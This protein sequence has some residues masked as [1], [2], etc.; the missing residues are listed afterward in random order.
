MEGTI[1]LL[2]G[3]EWD[4]AELVEKMYDDTFYY[5]YLGKAALSSSSM[6]KLTLS[7]EDYQDSLVRKFDS[8]A[9]IIGRLVHVA[10]LQPELIESMYQFIDCK[11][12]GSRL[13]KDALALSKEQEEHY[14]VVLEKD[15]IW[16]NEIRDAVL[17]HKTAAKLLSNGK[18]EIP[19]IDNIMGVP[20]RAKADWLRDD[21]IVD[22]KTTSNIDDF[23]YNCMQFGYD[24]QSYLYTKIFKRSKF[25]FIAVDKKSYKVEI[26]QASQEMIKDGEDKVRKA[27]SNYVQGYF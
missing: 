12:R 19:A 18:A 14:E 24:I 23:D 4:R 17:N 21:C 22:L 11:T 20:V 25:I 8:K 2:D 13:Y 26:K 10:V 16:S 3:K 7:V 1:T 5:G 27:I 6:K 15:R 9:L